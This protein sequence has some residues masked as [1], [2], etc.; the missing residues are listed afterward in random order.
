M[1][2]LKNLWERSF[3]KL[4]TGRA[5]REYLAFVQGKNARLRRF[6]TWTSLPQPSPT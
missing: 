1:K 4:R 6:A 3:D 5:R 2:P